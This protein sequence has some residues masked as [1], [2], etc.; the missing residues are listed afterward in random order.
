MALFRN[1]MLLLLATMAWTLPLESVE[2][3][4]NDLVARAG[5]TVYLIGD[6]TMA[7]GGGGSGTDGWG[8]YLQKYLP[9][10]TI[11]N[12]AVGGRSF[13]SFT[14]QGRFDAVAAAVKPGNWVVMEFGH[15]EHGSLR[16]DN[17]RTAC[18]GEGSE[19]CKV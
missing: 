5:A 19:I 16:N 12:H 3:A 4:D 2:Q 9:G 13:R 1:V 14:E 10:A 15:N 18:P 17:G 7:K 11:F 8:Q 6:S